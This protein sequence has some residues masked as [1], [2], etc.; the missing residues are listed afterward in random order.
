MTIQ[1]VF[2]MI[3]TF[4]FA[5]IG[6]VLELVGWRAMAGA[7]TLVIGLF[8]LPT[9]FGI[10]ERRRPAEEL[11]PLP[12]AEAIRLTLRNRP[13]RYLVAATSC[14]WFGLSGV[15]ALVPVWVKVSLGGAEGDVT[16]LMVPYLLMNL[17]FFFVFNALSRRCTKHVLL[18]ATFAGSS[19]TVALLLLVGVVPFGTLFMQ[20]AVIMTLV[21]APVAGFMVLPYVVLADVVD[22]DARLTGRRREAVYFGVQGVF[23]KAAIGLSI[24]AFT[25]VPYLGSADGMAVSVFGLKAMGLLCAAAFL[26]A[27]VIFLGYPIRERDGKAV[28]RGEE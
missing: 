23:Q 19:V 8:F 5:A 14:Y 27:A 1:S 28:V 3:G 4:L 15:L 21:G 18:L 20:T 2:M 25:L 10:R 16:R 9:L 22:Y 6:N 7:A 11:A 26:L 12:L 13:F 24:L 17:A